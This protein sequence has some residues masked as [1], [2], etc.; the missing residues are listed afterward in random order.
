LP[1]NYT[2]FGQVIEGIEIVDQIAG[3]AVTLSDSGE[4]SKPTEPVYIVNIEILRS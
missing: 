3:V 2:I 4:N 1:K